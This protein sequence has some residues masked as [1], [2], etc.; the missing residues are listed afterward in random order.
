MHIYYLHEVAVQ[1]D[2]SIRGTRLH[3][4]FCAV[5]R[6]SLHDDES[7]NCLLDKDLVE[8]PAVHLSLSLPI[9]GP[10]QQI[11][12]L[13]DRLLNVLGAGLLEE[14]VHDIR[15]VEIVEHV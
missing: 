12:A 2:F 3:G 8:D 11:D 13:T 9:V 1:P 14:G 15:G 4:D 10:V 6:C 7:I 5:L